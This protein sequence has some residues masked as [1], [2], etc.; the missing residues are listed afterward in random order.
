MKALVLESN[1][2]LMYR[3][4]PHPEISS[5]ECLVAVKNAGICRSDI[6][7]AYNNGAYFY[8]LI[9]GHEF[10]G[11]IKEVGNDVHNYKL[12][13]RVAVF[14]LIPCKNCEFCKI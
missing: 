7:R 5:D 8:P 2:K 13:D 1:E 11:I 4:V 12:G 3:D 14:P 9:M 10:A 6:Y